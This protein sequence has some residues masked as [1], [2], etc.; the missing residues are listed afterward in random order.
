MGK[1]QRERK[2]K[3]LAQKPRGI[4][5]S[6]FV[7]DDIFAGPISPP[8]QLVL[9]RMS[10]IR[11]VPE[12]RAIQWILDSAELR[13]EE[14]FWD[15]HL[16]DAVTLQAL[17][18]VMP[19][20][21]ARLERA[22]RISEDKVA[23]EFDEAR[24][25]MIGQVFTHELRREFRERF[26]RMLKRMLA[27]TKTDKLAMALYV[28]AMLAQKDLPWGIIGLV[29]RIFSE[30]QERAM[31]SMDRSD[32]LRAAV[33]QAMGIEGDAEELAKLLENRA[34]VEKLAHLVVSNP[35][36]DERI[37]DYIDETLDEFEHD[38]ASGVYDLE[39]FTPEQAA[40]TL[41]AIVKDNVKNDID[42]ETADS[43]MMQEHTSKF[44][45][46]ALQALLTPERLDEI[47]VVLEAKLNEWE[48]FGHPRT[49]A[50]RIEIEELRNDPMAE[51]PFLA[52]LYRGAMLK[53]THQLQQM[54]TQMEQ[55]EHP[56]APPPPDLADHIRNTFKRA[57]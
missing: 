12:E 45:V 40:H 10:D 22:A 18:R 42:P 46:A 25:E 2:E 52:A 21:E 51:N 33:S 13:E 7:G 56:I 44:I 14:E 28:R 39:V 54:A 17:N 3:K 48:R 27:G 32:E 24:I 30:S 31:A 15:F 55:R 20:F 8:A 53:L 50:L 11:E 29:T 34:S 49:Q 35:E 4:A 1:K 41:V 19:R 43:D 26:D 37:Q 16:D 57:N 6:P 23:E 36:L 9:N 38:V 5:P 47:Q